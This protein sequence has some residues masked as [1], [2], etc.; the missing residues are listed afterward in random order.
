[1]MAYTSNAVEGDVA[2]LA[3]RTVDI[4]DDMCLYFDIFLVLSNS[5]SEDIFRVNLALPQSPIIPA[6]TLYEITTW[7]DNQWRQLSF[8][9][10]K[11]TYVIQFEYTM[12]IPYRSAAAIDNVQLKSC[13]NQVLNRSR[14]DAFEDA[15]R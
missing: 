10:P 2:V 3:S 6:V 1:M 14:A 9:V 15:G 4:D 11:G 8:P 5:S 7:G 12:G 13:E